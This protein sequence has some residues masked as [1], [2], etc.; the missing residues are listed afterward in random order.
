MSKVTQ[1]DPIADEVFQTLSERLEDA[2]NG[3]IDGFMMLSVYK[4]SGALVTDLKGE[5]STEP[6]DLA[7]LIGY[8]DMMG[9]DLYRIATTD[10]EEYE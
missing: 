9:K 2:K 4:Q 10:D 1:I 8:L 7:L 3:K 6:D 5:F